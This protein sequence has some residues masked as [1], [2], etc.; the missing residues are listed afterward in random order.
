M[1]TPY[2]LE[3]LCNELACTPVGC[4]MIAGQGSDRQYYRIYTGDGRSFVGTIGPD[5]RENRA[6]CSL[7]R[8]FEGMGLNVPHI[9]AE[10]TDGSAYLQSDLGDVSLFDTLKHVCEDGVSDDARRLLGA[11]VDMLA[12]MHTAS[13]A[14][15]TYEMYCMTPSMGRR[16]IMWDLNYWKYCYLKPSGVQFDEA[17]LENALDRLVS[18]SCECRFEGL[19]LRDFQSRNVMICGGTPYVIDFQGARRGPL[20]YDVVSLLWQARAGLPEDVRW[21]YVR[22]YYDALGDMV[23]TVGSFETFRGE[24]SRMVLLRTLQ[25]LGAYG[26]RGYFERKQHFIDSIPG[27]IS[28]LRELL[29]YPDLTIDPYLRKVLTDVCRK[30]AESTGPAKLLTVTVRSFSFKKGRPDNSGNIHGGG[31]T[32]DCRALHNPGRYDEYKAMTGLDGPVI[33]FLER[34][35]EV[36]RFLDNVYGLIDQ[37]VE[38]YLRRGFDSLTVDFGCTGGQHRSVFCAHQTARHLWLKYNIRVVERHCVQDVTKDYYPIC[39]R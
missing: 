37:S 6:F 11:T 8:I 2:K 3:Q 23:R 5:I 7:S 10:S 15:R 18:S 9:V 36:Q 1:D 29:I 16:E 39:K 30:A 31:F 14:D 33:D 32:F 22:R 20:A 24:V 17:R 38:V 28:N 25:V 34:E 19:M 26:Y 13:Y 12:R 27:A 21:E 35:K 4:D